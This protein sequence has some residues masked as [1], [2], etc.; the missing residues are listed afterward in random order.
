MSVNKKLEDT[1]ISK[2]NKKGETS[3][4]G[5]GEKSGNHQTKGV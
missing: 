3:V 2:K 4:V 1:F 5:E